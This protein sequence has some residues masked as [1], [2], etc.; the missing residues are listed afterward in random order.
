MDLQWPR[1]RRARQWWPGQL[2]LHPDTRVQSREVCVPAALAYRWAMVA[3]TWK[4]ESWWYGWAAVIQHSGPPIEGWWLLPR[5]PEDV[6]LGVIRY[7]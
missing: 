4:G 3:V 5:D 7:G 2:C 6:A 1:N